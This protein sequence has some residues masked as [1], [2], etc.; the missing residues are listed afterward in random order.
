M[1]CVEEHVVVLAPLLS[2]VEGVKGL[3]EVLF[4]I[5]WVEWDVHV[6]GMGVV[7]G[8]GTPGLIPPIEQSEHKP[9]AKEGAAAAGRGRDTWVDEGDLVLERFAVFVELKWS[10]CSPTG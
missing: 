8:P 10:L 3:V 9:V 7:V 1:A 6:G 4:G 2:V 5:S